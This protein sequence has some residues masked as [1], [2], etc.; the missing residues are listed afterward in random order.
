MLTSV[1]NKFSFDLI[2]SLLILLICSGLLLN[3]AFEFHPKS[4]PKLGLDIQGGSFQ[5]YQFELTPLLEGKEFRTPEQKEKFVK[6]ILDKSITSLRGRLDFAGTKEIEI[7]SQGDQQIQVLVPKDLSAKEIENLVLSQ[8]SVEFREVMDTDINYWDPI[9][10]NFNQNYNAK[11][12]DTKWLRAFN[13]KHIEQLPPQ[14]ELLIEHTNG[15][16]PTYFIVDNYSWIDGSHIVSS[17]VGFSE[18]QNAILHIQL[19]PHGTRAYSELTSK[20]GR[21]FVIVMDKKIQSFLEVDEHITTNESEIHFSAGLSPEESLKEASLLNIV[22][23]AG[24]LPVDLDKVANSTIGPSLG[25]DSLQRASKALILAILAILVFLIYCYKTSGFI[26][27]LSSVFS[28]FL[29]LFLLGAI[30]TNLSLPGIAGFILS[31]G[32]AVDGGII[33]LERYKEKTESID[34]IYK[35]STWT[36]LDANITTALTAVVLAFF[37]SGPVRGFA[38]TLLVGILS[39]LLVIFSLQKVLLRMSKEG[40]RTHNY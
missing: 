29:S 31:I 17:R 18:N 9:I 6:S 33:L 34:E 15:K 1:R 16:N 19:D 37:T 8:G 20:K 12:Y 28:L 7:R 27:F 3:L 36:L 24:S 35:K 2:I 13:S 40:Q 39:S 14:S 4:L 11:L 23:K 25:K 30:G 10:E 26:V 32:L 38:I 21:Q 22:L 5:L